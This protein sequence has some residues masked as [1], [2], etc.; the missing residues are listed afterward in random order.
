M[1]T[2]I[3]RFEDGRIH[4]WNGPETLVGKHGD[5]FLC[6]QITDKVVASRSGGSGKTTAAR[7]LPTAQHATRP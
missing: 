5:V 1:K 6:R 3:P 4:E 7:G 2:G